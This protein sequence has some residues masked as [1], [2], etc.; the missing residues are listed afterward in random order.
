MEIAELPIDKGHHI[1]CILLYSVDI[2]ADSVCIQK[3]SRTV[4]INLILCKGKFV[5]RA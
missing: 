3:Y 1:F 5:A 2:W 4:Q